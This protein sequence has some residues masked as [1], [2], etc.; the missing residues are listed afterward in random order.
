MQAS[1]AKPAIVCAVIDETRGASLVF[2]GEIV[3]RNVA[4]GLYRLSIVKGGPA[5][6][7]T[8]RQGGAFTSRSEQAV[9]VGGGALSLEPGSTYAISLVVEMGGRSIDCAPASGKQP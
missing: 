5:G 7:S 9:M 6:S 8:I 2:H 4:S 1:D 3:T